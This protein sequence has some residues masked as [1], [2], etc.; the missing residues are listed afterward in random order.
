MTSKSVFF[1]ASEL[2]TIPEQFDVPD[3]FC[4]IGEFSKKFKVRLE[5]IISTWLDGLC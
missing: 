3:S 1:D 5:D 4:S 2:F